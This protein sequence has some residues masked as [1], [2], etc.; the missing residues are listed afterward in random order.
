MSGEHS[1]EGI[2]FG[3]RLLLTSI[4]GNTG[5]VFEMS[6]NIAIGKLSSLSEV[7]GCGVQEIMMFGPIALFRLTSDIIPP[8]SKLVK[9]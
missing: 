3:R 7:T 6:G 4:N 5:G 9:W 2:A 1:V 8:N